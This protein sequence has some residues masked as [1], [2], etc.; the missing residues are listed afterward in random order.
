MG[1]INQQLISGGMGKLVCPCRSYRRAPHSPKRPIRVPRRI[2][3]LPPRSIR[4]QKCA[5]MRAF[6]RFFHP[7]SDP[8]TPVCDYPKLTYVS[9]APQAHRAKLFF[10]YGPSAPD[11]PAPRHWHDV[12]TPTNPTTPEEL[13]MRRTNLLTGLAA[14]AGAYLAGRTILN[15]LRHFDLRDKV[16]LV[17]GGSRGLGLLLAREFGSRGARVAACARNPVE[18]QRAQRMLCKEGVALWIG[19][20]DI[21]RQDQVEGLVGR[22]QKDLGHVDV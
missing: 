9:G 16:V 7:I 18:L 5:K 14:T 19:Q 6:A 2:N 22:V 17:T 20:C 21:T 8:K 11:P 3:Q 10:L 1:I 15:R 4:A 13:T 12:C